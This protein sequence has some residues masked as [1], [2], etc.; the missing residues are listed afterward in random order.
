MVSIV[1][2]IPLHN[3]NIGT[4]P[5]PSLPRLRAGWPTDLTL[6]QSED[7]HP[8]G[9]TR[10][11]KKEVKKFYPLNLA[12]LCVS[13]PDNVLFTFGLKIRTELVIK[14][15]STVLHYCENFSKKRKLLKLSQ[16][17]KV[18]SH[19]TRLA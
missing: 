17:G 14:T 6:C 2:T 1:T 11:F 7:R 19:Q 10:S 8:R 3:I 5:P 15:E 9:K 13:V 4:A 16:G 12:F 18:P